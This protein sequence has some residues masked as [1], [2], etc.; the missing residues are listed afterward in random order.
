MKKFTDSNFKI[1]TD[2]NKLRINDNPIILSSTKKIRKFI[3]WNV[4]YDLKTSL[5][6]TWESKELPPSVE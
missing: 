1:I 4:K 6:D 5:K 3:D 2:K